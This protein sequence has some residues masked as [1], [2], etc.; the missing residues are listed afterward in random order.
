MQCAVNANGAHAMRPGGLGE[1]AGVHEREHAFRLAKV[2][3]VVG[4]V[5]LRLKSGPSKPMIMMFRLRCR[6]NVRPSF[7]KQSRA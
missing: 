2:D 1:I 6:T 4:S 7:L 5:A 3:L